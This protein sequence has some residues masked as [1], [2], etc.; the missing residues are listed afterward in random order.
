[1]PDVL[2]NCNDGTNQQRTVNSNGTGRAR[3]DH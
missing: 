1:M 2:Y 3:G